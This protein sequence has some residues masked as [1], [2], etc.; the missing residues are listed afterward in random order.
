[1]KMAFKRTL[2]SVV[3]GRDGKPDYIKMKDDVVLKKDQILNLESA[4]SQMESLQKAVAAGKL[5]AETGEKIKDRIS[6]IPEWV[7]FEIT[8]YEDKK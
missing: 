6:K 3:K 5:S 7:R 8:M 4:K 2:G 1:M